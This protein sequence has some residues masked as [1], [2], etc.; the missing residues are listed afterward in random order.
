MKKR[1]IYI[2]IFF[3]IYIN[4]SAS[5]STPSLNEI[6]SKKYCIRFSVTESAFDG[7]SINTKNFQGDLMRTDNYIY[8]ESDSSGVDNLRMAEFLI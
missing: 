1:N 7:D 8:S 6:L 2:S 4:S 5:D 3:L